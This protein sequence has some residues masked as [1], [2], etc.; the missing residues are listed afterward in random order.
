MNGYDNPDQPWTIVY[1]SGTTENDRLHV[2]EE[3]WAE[4]KA[5]FD[6]IMRFDYTPL[7]NAATQQTENS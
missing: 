7:F 5:T 2:T 6:D 3:E 4:R 1:G